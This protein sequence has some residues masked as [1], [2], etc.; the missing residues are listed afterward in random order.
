MGLINRFI[1]S[2][3]LDRQVS[4][5]AFDI[6]E[7]DAFIYTD[8]RFNYVFNERY[9]LDAIVNNVLDTEPPFSGQTVEGTGRGSLYDNIGRFY[10]LQFTARF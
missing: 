9:S 3:A 6:N 2:S 5:E 1:G 7:V 4:D 10:Q 8:V